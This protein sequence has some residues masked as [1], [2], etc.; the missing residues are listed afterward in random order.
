MLRTVKIKTA[1]QELV[2]RVLP[3]FT[4][5]E[6]LRVNRLP[7]SLF[8]GYL[9]VS[10]SSR[11]IPLTHRIGDFEEGAEIVL[12]CIRNT[13]L[14]QVLPQRTSYQK[15]EG[16]I[17]SIRDVQF[18]AGECREVI[19]EVDAETA[20]RIVAGRVGEFLRVHSRDSK[21]LVGISGGGDSNT[22]VRSLK[23]Y[24]KQNAS[25][26][27]VVC[28]TLVFDP[29]WPRRGLR[30][31]SQ[32][33]KENG[34]VHLVYDAASIE[35][36][37]GMRIGLR[38]FYDDFSKEFGVH[39]A[40][41]FATYLISLVA[42][43]LCRM[44][45]TTEYCLG[46]NREDVLAELLFSLMNGH[47]PLSF[48]VREF[49]SIRLLMP[50]WE[51]PKKVLDACYPKYS[52]EN[53]EERLDTTT[54]QRSLIYYLAHSIEDIYSNLGLSLIKGIQVLFERDWSPLRHEHDWDLYVSDYASAEQVDAVKKLLREHFTLP[55]G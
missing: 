34:A 14:R 12:Q 11:P 44:H 35:E 33:C 1:S 32:L 28:F 26:H 29:I 46:F 16:A 2:L 36:L 47:R 20:Q 42:R 54:I 3:E 23:E 22:L 9:H 45:D 50:L 53:Y 6:V 21:I 52:I 40:H 31:A 18:A 15:R 37:L 39:T 24:A 17:T 41:F 13:D 27:G 43:K 49:G 30:R 5:A 19:E 7:E 51:I 8:Q 48:P 55:I 4:L 10:S 25:L 38:A